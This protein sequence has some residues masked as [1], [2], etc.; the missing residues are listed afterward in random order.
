M[1]KFNRK[2]ILSKL[3]RMGKDDELSQPIIITKPEKSLNDDTH[4]NGLPIEEIDKP[5]VEMLRIDVKSQQELQSPF[6]AL[7]IALHMKHLATWIEVDV[8][9]T[10][11]R[12]YWYI[13]EYVVPELEKKS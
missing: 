12:G 8:T 3:I 13:I 9:A 10:N 5:I 11:S 7:H 6:H 2:N 1:P 4:Y